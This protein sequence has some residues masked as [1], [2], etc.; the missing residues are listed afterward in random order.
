MKH[1]A[2]I[3]LSHL[4][5]TVV[6]TL[7]HHSLPFTQLK[8]CVFQHD[9]CYTIPQQTLLVNMIIRILLDGLEEKTIFAKVIVIGSQKMIFSSFGQFHQKEFS[10]F[11]PFP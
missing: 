2:I 10:A 3:V 6:W 5:H 1:R 11:P 8:A 7:P 9:A 4:A